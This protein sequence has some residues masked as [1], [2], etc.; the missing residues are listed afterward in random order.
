MLLP[1]TIYG[2]SVLR[3][4]TSEVTPDDEGLLQFIDNMFET[5]KKSDGIGLAAPQVNS[6]RRLFIVDGTPLSDEHPELAEFKQPFINPEITG[7]SEEEIFAEEGC[8]SIPGIREEVR[9]PENITI[10]YYDRNFKE[11]EET[12]SGIAARIIQHE[13]DHLNGVL[14]TDRLS[15][16]TK[17]ML[18]K[19]LAAISKGKFEVSYKTVVV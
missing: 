13:F 14:F 5:L 17:R 2:N 3:K 15:P 8:L 4:V 7:F 9:R 10:R 16:L 19:K 11:H 18:R 12:Y 1:I 6:M